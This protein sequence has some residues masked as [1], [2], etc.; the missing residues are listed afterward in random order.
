[1]ASLYSGNDRVLARIM[2][3][4]DKDLIAQRKAVEGH[5]Q[6]SLNLLS[7]GPTIPGIARRA[8]RLVSAWPLVGRAHVPETGPSHQA[9]PD[10]LRLLDGAPANP[11]AARQHPVAMHLP[12]LSRG[13]VARVY[14]VNLIRLAARKNDPRS[15][16]QAKI[17]SP[18]RRIRLSH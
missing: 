2:E 7:V 14:E 16:L 9:R 17:T 3:V 12:G 6:C 13:H 5:K 10:A 15:S 11:N 8:K 1:M 18:H 4:D